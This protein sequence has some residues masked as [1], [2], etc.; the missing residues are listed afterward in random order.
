MPTFAGSSGG[1]QTISGPDNWVVFNNGDK[2]KQAAIDFVKWLTAPEQVKA[3]SLAH[4][5][6]AHP[7]VGGQ[8]QAVRR[9]S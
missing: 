2:R 6:P 3:Y 8:D 4:R 1:H 5:R 9:Q 7:H